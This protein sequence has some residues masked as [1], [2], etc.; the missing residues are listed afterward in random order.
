MDSQLF[1]AINGLAAHWRWLD[2]L[3]VFLAQY[4]I[5]IFAL[6]VAALLIKKHYRRYVYLAIAASSISRAVIVEVLKRWIGRARPYEHLPVHQLLT[7]HERSLSFPSGHAVI[8]FSLAFA[9]YG[10]KYFWPF[11]V[12]ACLGSLARVFVGVHYP[13]DIV[14]SALIAW[15]VVFV[16]RRFFR[17]HFR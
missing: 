3:G 1:L 15:V 16:L 13:A 4:F 5:Y 8:F 2:E 12:L 6:S 17:H 14:A 9:F 7:D 11:F 10:T